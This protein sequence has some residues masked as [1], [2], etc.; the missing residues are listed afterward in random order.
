MS[1]GVE[2]VLCAPYFVS[3][4]HREAGFSWFLNARSA[5]NT[6]KEK[7]WEILYVLLIWKH[8]LNPVLLIKQLIQTFSTFPLNDMAASLMLET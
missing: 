3:M 4:H 2:C 5:E 7:L 6:P 8:F 1:G